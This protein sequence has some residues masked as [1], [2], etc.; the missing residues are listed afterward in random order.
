[1]HGCKTVCPALLLRFL[2]INGREEPA[3]LEALQAASDPSDGIV[4][5][6]SPHHAVDPDRNGWWEVG[7]RPPGT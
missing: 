4:R 3:Q 1:M 5:A 2:D 6:V 7:A